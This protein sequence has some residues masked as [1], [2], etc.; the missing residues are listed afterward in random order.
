MTKHT[1]LNSLLLAASQETK[2]LEAERVFGACGGVCGEIPC[3]LWNMGRKSKQERLREMK[4]QGEERSMREQLADE[5]LRVAQLRADLE[6]KDRKIQELSTRIEATDTYNKA[7]VLDNQGMREK[8]D[9][10]RRRAYRV[11]REL[12]PED[13]LAADHWWHN[14][15]DQN[16]NGADAAKTVFRSLRWAHREIYRREAN[17]KTILAL[18]NQV[19]TLEQEARGRRSLES[20]GFWRWQAEGGNDLNSLTCN[21]VITPAELREIIEAK[22]QAEAALSAVSR[23]TLKE[24]KVSAWEGSKL[25]MGRVDIVLASRWYGI[26]HPLVVK[27]FRDRHGSVGTEIVPSTGQVPIHAVDTARGLDEVH[28][29]NWILQHRST[30]EVQVL[31]SKWFHKAYVELPVPEEKL[32]S[33]EISYVPPPPVS[34]PEDRDVAARQLFDRIWGPW[35]PEWSQAAVDKLVAQYRAD[36]SLIDLQVELNLAVECA[37]VQKLN[38]EAAEKDELKALDARDKW[39]DTATELADEVGSYFGVP[40]GEHSSANCPIEEAKKILNGEYKLSMS[41]PV[42]KVWRSGY[43]AAKAQVAAFDL[44][45]HLKRRYQPS[46][47]REFT[48]SILLTLEVVKERMLPAME[49]EMPHGWIS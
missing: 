38:A 34:D 39:E 48:P 15:N 49:P 12:I 28:I 26:F 8:L 10:E 11:K 37:R 32:T 30:G 47:W 17:D 3:V 20:D 1:G 44:L 36:A 18:E 2:E 45:D 25:F 6:E 27:A 43:D 16:L 46:V 23:E 29:G 21:I 31:H 22:E 35:R 7:L 19:A 40:V 33:E 5:Y 9:E 42:G 14:V 41:S 13:Y 4:E 24:S